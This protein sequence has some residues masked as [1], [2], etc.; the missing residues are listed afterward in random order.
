ML[1][2]WRALGKISEDY[3]VFVHL[4]NERGE[5]IAQQDAP[6]K[7]GNAPTSSWG[8]GQLIVDAHVVTIPIDA[9]AGSIYRLE[10][11]LYDAGTMRRLEIRDLGDGAIGDTLVIQPF[12][13]E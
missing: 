2:Y 11:G 8:V 13:V 9:P 4:V 12:R 7:N 1:L 6:P 5:I 3:T 10:V